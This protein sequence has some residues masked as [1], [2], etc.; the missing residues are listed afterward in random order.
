[1]KKLK[2]VI[3]AGIIL[4]VIIMGFFSFIYKGA[5][6]SIQVSSR[7]T[8]EE[9][10][11]RGAY[12]ARVGD[13]MACHTH[14]TAGG[15]QYAGGLPIN[16]PVGTIYSTNITPDVKTG[17]GSYTLQDFDNAMRYG[18]RQNGDSLYPAMPFPDFAIVRDEDIE[19]LYVYFMHGVEPVAQPNQ[20]TDIPW[21]LS[22]RW[23]LAAWRMVFSPKV[24]PRS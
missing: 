16:S 14:H 2:L 19:A 10:I 15:A 7:L 13:C 3:I 5:T 22:M 9:L 4:L 21:P 17:I 23:P 18:V 20:A 11:N 1:M 12:L 24:N 6:S 8:Q